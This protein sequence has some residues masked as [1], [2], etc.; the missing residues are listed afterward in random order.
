MGLFDWHHSWLRLLLAKGFCRR[1]LWEGVLLKCKTGAWA[2]LLCVTSTSSGCYFKTGSMKGDSMPAET[3]PSSLLY[4]GH[5]QHK[6][7]MGV[8]NRVGWVGWASRRLFWVLPSAGHL[9][10]IYRQFIGISY[11]AL[12]RQVQIYR[13]ISD[14]FGRLGS[15]LFWYIVLQLATCKTLYLF[16]VHCNSSHSI[17]VEKGNLHMN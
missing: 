17:E 9:L 14:P 6:G 1:F 2:A 11:I 3:T 15:W 4:P 12:A 7:L 10:W 13:N 5:W 8:R 16:T